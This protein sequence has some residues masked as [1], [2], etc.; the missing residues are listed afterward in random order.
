MSATTLYRPS[1]TSDM[2]STPEEVSCHGRRTFSE[3]SD[4]TELE[5]AGVEPI[6][7][8]DINFHQSYAARDIPRGQQQTPARAQTRLDWVVC[9]VNQ[10]CLSFT[11]LLIKLYS[12]IFINIYR[13]LEMFLLPFIFKDLYSLK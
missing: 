1:A 12:T 13:G 3:C 8:D 4:F 2:P 9:C 6:T 11:I 5:V 7:L 10:G